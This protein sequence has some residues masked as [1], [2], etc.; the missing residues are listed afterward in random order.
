M[1]TEILDKWKYLTKKSYP[2]ESFKSIVDYQK[3]VD[4]LRKEHFLTKLKNDFPDDKEI[5]R[6]KKIIKRFNIKSGEELT[7]LF[8][9]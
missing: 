2:Y 1:K 6:T 8:K 3:P 4:N 7:D 9:K 5:E